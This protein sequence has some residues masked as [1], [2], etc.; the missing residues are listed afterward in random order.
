MKKDI[1][2]GISAFLFLFVSIS[3]QANEK[4]LEEYSVDP[5]MIVEEY[6]Q[7]NN[8]TRIPIRSGLF[9]NDT[10]AAIYSPYIYHTIHSFP[11]ETIIK[12]DDGSEWIFDPKD[13][14]IVRSWR[15]NNRDYPGIEQADTVVLSPKAN[16]FNNWFSGSNYT[17]VLQNKTLNSAIDVD[18]FHGPP[19][20][21]ELTTW[22]VAMNINVGQF[23][24]ING[25]KER[26]IWEVS[27]SD[28]YLLKDWIVNDIVVIGENTHW[29]S[30]FSS[31]NHIVIN[32]NKNNFVRARQISVNNFIKPGES[33]DKTQHP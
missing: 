32:L 14:Y 8:G 23:F 21:G 31:Y 29:L 18:F 22:V 9:Q 12:L 26:T 24:I 27:S 25:Q 6:E 15:T 5:S 30:L 28:L 17:Y 13:S 16:G 7:I 20:G 10:A 2:K 1:A 11:Q 33:T 19:P 4:C 3:T